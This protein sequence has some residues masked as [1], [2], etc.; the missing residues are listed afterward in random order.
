[1][2]MQKVV[3]DSDIIIDHLREATFT[4]EQ[5]LEQIFQKQIQ[6]YIPSVVITEIYSGQDTKRE[7]RLSLIKRI[8]EKLEFVASS[9]EIS[10]QAGFLM[11][12]YRGLKLADAII[13]ATTLSLDAKLATRNK[14][15]FESIK[16]LKFFKL[17]K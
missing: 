12:D 5:V 7:D 17:T 10:Q 9:K 13:A 16:E 15:D 6:A 11:R 4:L 14:K 2:V 3:L 8:L 1:M